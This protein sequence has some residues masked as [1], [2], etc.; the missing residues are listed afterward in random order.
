MPFR[1]PTVFETGHSLAAFTFQKLRV[2]FAP[3]TFPLRGEGS[4]TELPEH[5]FD[6]WRRLT[7]H[8]GF[9]KSLESKPFASFGRIFANSFG[10]GIRQ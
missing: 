2:G 10:D 4:A 1:A 8:E 3:T 5:V 6:G 7:C 9:V